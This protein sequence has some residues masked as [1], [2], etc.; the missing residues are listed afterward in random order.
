VGQVLDF[1]VVN[2]FNA[3]GY[4]A[5]QTPR[6]NSANSAYE[7]GTACWL[8][9]AQ[10]LT[11]QKTFET[12]AAGASPV[13]YRQ[14]GGTANVDEGQ[15]G[16]SGT[17]F[18]IENKDGTFRFINASNGGFHFRSQNSGSIFKITNGNDATTFFE[19]NDAAGGIVTLPVF[20]IVGDGRVRMG[21][22][23]SF[24]FS[25][26]TAAATE[27][28]TALSRASAAGLVLHDAGLTGTPFFGIQA[29]SSTTDRRDRVRLTT[30]AVDNTD[31]TR[32]YRGILSVY[33]T[34]AREA[35]R[36][37]ASGTAAMLGFYGVAAVA[38]P[39]GIADADGT[40]ASATAKINAILAALESL[41]LLGVA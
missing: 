4:A 20:T 13:R 16:H 7:W 40:L 1:D 6:R 33:D 31:A 12:G 32:K 35:M 8:D 36:V 24:G 39:A 5:L 22:G 25:S 37:E 10:T 17:V 15:I 29:R 34:A 9:E 11:G 18:T 19:F 21:S 14:T 30:A 38:Q 26:G 28:D 41:G 3:R 27:L 23:N 2:L